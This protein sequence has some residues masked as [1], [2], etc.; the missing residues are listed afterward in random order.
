MTSP[1]FDTL[2]APTV[3]VQKMIWTALAVG[4]AVHVAMAYVFL[5]MRGTP[6]TAGVSDIVT[7]VI[8][9]LS[10]V[11]FL[12]TI[13]MRRILFADARVDAALAR[14]DAATSVAARAHMASAGSSVQS[15]QEQLDALSDAEMHALDLA[16]WC[17]TQFIVLW[18]LAESI[19]V[20]GLTLSF[21]TGDIAS[22]FPMVMGALVLLAISFPNL[23]P[24]L[25]RALGHRVSM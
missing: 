11:T 7:T 19:S 10:G 15:V 25:Q 6:A 16:A 14:D 2:L 3:R 12:T 17:T 21:L 9:V 20:F 23:D 1:T 13:A 24:L 22:M 18:A 5:D 4:V 8:S